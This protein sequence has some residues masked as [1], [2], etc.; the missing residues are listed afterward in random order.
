MI[1]EEVCNQLFP[2]RR[3]RQ[4]YDYVSML[5]HGAIATQL[6]TSEVIAPIR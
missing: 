1:Y 3:A 2:V 4:P 6:A 5:G